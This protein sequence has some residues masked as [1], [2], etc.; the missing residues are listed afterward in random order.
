MRCELSILTGFCKMG[1][2]F[3]SVYLISRRGHSRLR[4]GRGG[5]VAFRYMTEPPFRTRC[6]KKSV[7][8]SP[9]GCR[10]AFLQV[11]VCIGL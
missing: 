5:A 8:S 1:S 3:F 9:S 10:A 11:A 4:C 2:S 6:E 7:L